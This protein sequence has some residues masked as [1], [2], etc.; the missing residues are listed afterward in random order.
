MVDQ[1][2]QNIHHVW[3]D[4][5]ERDGRV[6]AAGS[7]VCLA[8]ENVFMYKTTS[9]S[10]FIHQLLNTHHLRVFAVCYISS[11][12]LPSS[13]KEIYALKRSRKVERIGKAALH[14]S[15]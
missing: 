15:L 14:E 4:V 2:L 6:A 3:R 8:E 13:W 12:L 10:L 1:I 11:I 5:V 7:S 9:I